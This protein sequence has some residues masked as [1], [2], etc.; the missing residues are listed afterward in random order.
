MTAALPVVAPR[1][2]LAG[3]SLFAALILEM[4]QKPVRTPED[5]MISSGV[6]V[7]AVLPPSSSRR[8]QRL[9]GQT[10]PTM[11]PPTLRLG[12]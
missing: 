4:V 11:R 2:G 8:P 1:A 7:L 6:P 12:S 10:G 3:W 5:L 9:I